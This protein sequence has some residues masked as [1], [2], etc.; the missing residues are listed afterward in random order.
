VSILEVVLI[1][2]GWFGL[3]IVVGAVVVG[4]GRR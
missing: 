1:A 3:G 2:A 4:G